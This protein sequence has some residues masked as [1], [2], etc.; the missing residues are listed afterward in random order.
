MP[1]FCGSGQPFAPV[2]AIRIVRMDLSSLR[3]SLFRPLS[4]AVTSAVSVFCAAVLCLHIVTYGGA[5]SYCPKCTLSHSML[6]IYSF[7]TVKKFDKINSQN[8]KR[9]TEN[10]VSYR[11]KRAFPQ[12]SSLSRIRGK[13]R[14]PRHKACFGLRYAPYQSL[15]CTISGPDKA[16]IVP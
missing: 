8:R 11:A 2:S 9:R 13:F 16:Y 5:L 14:R 6:H 10:F 15:V 3:C 7:L 1:P 12:P 4:L